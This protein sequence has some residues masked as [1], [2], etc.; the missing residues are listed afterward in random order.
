VFLL[1]FLIFFSLICWF[2]L[3]RPL[4]AEM[5]LT[6]GDFVLQRLRPKAEQCWN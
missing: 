6:H 3:K 5:L 1:L 2:I 4:D